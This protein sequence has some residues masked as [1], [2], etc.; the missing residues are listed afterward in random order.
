VALRSA[1]RG[2]PGAAVRMASFDKEEI[3]PG[4]DG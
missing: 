3:A 4:R 1:C 2:S